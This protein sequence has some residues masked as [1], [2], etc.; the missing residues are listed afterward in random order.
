M[1]KEVRL[2]NNPIKDEEFYTEHGCC[3]S[4]L[5]KAVLMLLFGTPAAPGDWQSMAG[6]GRVDLQDAQ[7]QNS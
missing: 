6:N 3:V 1:K 7:G 5:P 4:R 2:M